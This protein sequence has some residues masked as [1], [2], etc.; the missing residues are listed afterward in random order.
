MGYRP[1]KM[2]GH[3]LPGPNQK[4]SAPTKF[5]GGLFGGGNKGGGGGIGLSNILDPAGLFG[6]GGLFGNK[7]GGGQAGQSST[8]G[9]K[10]S[11]DVNVNINRKGGGG[12]GG[13][14]ENIDASGTPDVETEE[15]T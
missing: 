3:E 9:Q 2:K 5:L 15:I 11:V 8:P 1:F 7:R 4:K 14:T 12:G 10:H 13:A 6:G